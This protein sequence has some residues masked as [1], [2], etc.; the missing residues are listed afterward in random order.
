M[1]NADT[2][3]MPLL[4]E[5]GVRDLTDGHVDSGYLSQK[6]RRFS[7]GLTKREHF[8]AMAMQGI[9]GS[10][11][12]VGQDVNKAKVAQHAIEYA[13]ALLAELDK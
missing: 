4:D 13:D 3:A 8:A 1:N 7:I 12:L 5:H 9:I 11:N 2:P 10:G 6:G